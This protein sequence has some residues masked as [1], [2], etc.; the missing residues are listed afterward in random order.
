MK[1]DYNRYCHSLLRI[2]EVPFLFVFVCR[3]SALSNISAANHSR[4]IFPVHQVFQHLVLR[5]RA[6]FYF[7]LPLFRYH[8]Q[9]LII[10][11]FPCVRI[12]IRLCK[13][14]QMPDAPRNEIAVPLHVSRRL[15]LQTAGTARSPGAYAPQYSAAYCQDR[16]LCR[17][18]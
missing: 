18:L 16:T 6:A 12:G 13:L 3:P 15:C 2:E 8:G 9:A 10:P 11:F 4:N 1:K 17:L 14:H 5:R 7:C